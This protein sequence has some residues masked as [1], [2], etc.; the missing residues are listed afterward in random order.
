[1][2]G[3]FPSN[4]CSPMP[5]PEWC[6]QRF[7]KQVSQWLA[8]LLDIGDRHCWF[9]I[10]AEGVSK[11]ANP[12][13]HWEHCGTII[14]QTYLRGIC[15]VSLLLSSMGRSNCMVPFISYWSLIWVFQ[16][17]VWQL[18]Y[19]KPKKHILTASMLRSNDRYDRP[20]KNTMGCFKITPSSPY[21]GWSTG[22]ELASACQ[23]T[24]RD[25]AVGGKVLC[26]EAN[27]QTTWASVRILVELQRKHLKHGFWSW[28]FSLSNAFRS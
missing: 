19:F 24:S 11:R 23:L 13:E 18:I 21:R 3:C 16:I 28:F 26:D 9:E 27:N 22:S 4:S 5:S 15:P 2:I 25:I 12:C 20:R 6:S 8:E 1:M 10:T 7:L 14:L 17:V